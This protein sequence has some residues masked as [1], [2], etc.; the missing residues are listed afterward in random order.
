MSPGRDLGDDASELRVQVGLRRDHVRANLAIVGH[1]RGGRLVAR[2]LE[3][4]NHA[5]G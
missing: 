2:R 1:E 4:E 3:G 5:T